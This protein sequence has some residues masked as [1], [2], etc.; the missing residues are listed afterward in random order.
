MTMSRAAATFRDRDV[1]HSGRLTF[2]NQNAA[3]AKP[4]RITVKG[5]D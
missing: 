5:R 3:Q 2:F 1:A 4:E